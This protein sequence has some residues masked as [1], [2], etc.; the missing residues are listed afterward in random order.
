M[1]IIIIGAGGH[2]AEI[3]DY[4]KYSNALNSNASEVEILGYLD[5]DFNNYLHYEL[6]F[7]YLGSISEHEVVTDV[8]YIIGI[9]NLDYR[10]SIVE[11]FLE[12]GAKFFT[13]IHPTASISS[14]AKFGQGVVIAPNVNLGPNAYVGD[15]SLVNSRVSL[16]H[17]SKI[18]RY[19]FLSPNVCFSGFTHVGDENLFGINSATIPG[20]RIGNRNNIMAGMT[21]DKNIGDEQVV[22]HRFK[23]KVNMIKV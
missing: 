12:R 17:D 6:T 10:K 13:Y 14:S 16:G 3:T 11:L 22:F 2:A 20:I 5:D 8:H 15:F 23:E 1:K 19:N 21:L 9:S 18:G 4:L 7:S